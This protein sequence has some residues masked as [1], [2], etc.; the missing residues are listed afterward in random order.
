MYRKDKG[1]VPVLA[2][3]VNGEPVVVTNDEVKGYIEDPQ[4]GY[5]L[6][7]YNYTKLWGL[8]NGNGWANEPFEILEGITAIELE[9]K[10]IEHEELDNARK[11]TS[12]TSV[13]R[14]GGKSG[15]K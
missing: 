13:Q 6:G 2:I 11:R 4:F 5:V 3:E 1:S 14:G 12:D 7:V 10:T 8:P 15:N 9:A